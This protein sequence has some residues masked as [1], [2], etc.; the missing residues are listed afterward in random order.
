MTRYAI[1]PFELPDRTLFLEECAAEI[2]ADLMDVGYTHVQVGT[3]RHARSH[4]LDWSDFLLWVDE[5]DAWDD[6]A[7]GRLAVLDKFC[8]EFAEHRAAFLED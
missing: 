2:K 1:N 7:T 3:G 6:L 5:S 8:D 4:T